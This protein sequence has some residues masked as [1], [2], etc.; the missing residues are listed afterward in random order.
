V[1]SAIEE[2]SGWE[3]RVVGR[4]SYGLIRE[5]TR[6]TTGAQIGQFILKEEQDEEYH[7]D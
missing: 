5:M 1:G 7:S 6:R 3:E 2:F 4:K